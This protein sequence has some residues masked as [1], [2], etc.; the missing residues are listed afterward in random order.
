VSAKKA[1]KGKDVHAFNQLIARHPDLSAVAMLPVRDG[2]TLALYD[3]PRL[4]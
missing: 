4:Q 2:L 3:P 1:A